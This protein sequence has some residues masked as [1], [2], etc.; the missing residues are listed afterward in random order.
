MPLIKNNT[1]RTLQL[2]DLNGVFLDVVPGGSINSPFFYTTISGADV[3]SETPYYQDIKNFALA[4]GTASTDYLHQVSMKSDSIKILNTTA[5]N[6]MLYLNSKS[7][8]PY[9]VPKNDELEIPNIK[10]RVRRVY[11]D[12]TTD[13]TSGVY[14]YEYK[15]YI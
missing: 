12:F 9:V 10:D 1:Y 5:D 7:T 8:Y 2:M 13:V 11:L 3:V 14:I 15:N 4:S 6:V